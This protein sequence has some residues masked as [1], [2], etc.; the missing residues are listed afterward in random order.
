MRAGLLQG[1]CLALLFLAQVPAVSADEAPASKA[2]TA[3]RLEVEK[4]VVDIGEVARGK[5]AE[6]V[7][8][9]KNAGTDTLRILSAKP[10]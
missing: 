8:V 1:S 3:P 4:F 7:F 10:T 5:S 9:L 2:P 6:A